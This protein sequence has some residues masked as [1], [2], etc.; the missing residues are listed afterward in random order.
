MLVISE[1]YKS[2][3]EMLLLWSECKNIVLTDSVACGLVVL[4]GGVGEMRPVLE[5]LFHR[6]LLYPPPQCRHDALRAVSEV[7]H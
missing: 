7:G 5:S 3:D 1:I 4:M 2:C 6:M